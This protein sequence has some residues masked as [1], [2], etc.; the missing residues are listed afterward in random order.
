MKKI[1]A[2][3]LAVFTLVAFS[4]YRTAQVDR[5]VKAAPANVVLQS[6]SATPIKS[7]SLPR[8][9]FI[10]QNVSN[11]NAYS[12]VPDIGSYAA[13]PSSINYTHPV[14]GPT[15]E[16]LRETCASR[17]G[18]AGSGLERLPWLAYYPGTNIPSNEQANNFEHDDATCSVYRLEGGRGEWLSPY[19]NSWALKGNYST[20][21]TNWKNAVSTNSTA[22]DTTLFSDSPRAWKT[23][24]IVPADYDFESLL[25]GKDVYDTYQLKSGGATFYR[26]EF[27]LTE[28]QLSAI[29]SITI[30]SKADDF[31][32]V[33]LNGI[34]QDKPTMEKNVTHEPGVAV[35]AVNVT[36]D[37]TQLVGASNIYNLTQTGNVVAFQ[38]NDKAVWHQN[39]AS[40]N[41]N[42]AGLWF[43]IQINFTETPTPALTCDA[44][45]KEGLS[46]LVVMVTFG[47]GSGEYSVNM[48]DGTTLSNRTSPVYY[49]YAEAGDYDIIITDSASATCPVSVNV[50]DPTDPDGGEVAP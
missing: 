22:V 47:G 15:T 19:W 26:M 48:G 8:A 20:D 2:F 24:T 34:T 29:D 40:S 21:A 13:Y 12:K 16:T 14:N 4:Y 50:T 25:F 31:Q 37:K 39:G 32:K 43:N 7:G 42:R 36:I 5:E 46:P 41:S 17:E 44:T 10:V 11:A 33:Y 18:G 38:V 49:T 35:D 1:F 30:N 27:D 9:N 3:V 6:S 45:P 28:E 23:N